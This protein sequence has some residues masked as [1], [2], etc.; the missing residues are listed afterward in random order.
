MPGESRMD[1]GW[2]VPR[3]RKAR[4]SDSTKKRP[5]STAVARVSRLA[6]PR[7]VMKAPMPWEEPMPR[8]PPSLR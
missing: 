7:P 8:P 6:V 2:S 1:R 4:V 3:D 5:A